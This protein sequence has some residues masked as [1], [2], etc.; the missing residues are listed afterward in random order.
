MST[1]AFA[2]KFNYTFQCIIVSLVHIMHLP[3]FCSAH[4]MCSPEHVICLLFV[5]PAF[6]FHRNLS[7]AYFFY[8]VM[9]IL[10]VLINLSKIS[11]NSMLFFL[12]LLELCTFFLLSPFSILTQYFFSCLLL[13]SHLITLPLTLFDL[14]HCQFHNPLMFRMNQCNLT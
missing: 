2:M 6:N 10:C 11:Q 13:A 8:L 1:L 12:K 14:L 4:L 9:Q 3:K 5:E 7:Y